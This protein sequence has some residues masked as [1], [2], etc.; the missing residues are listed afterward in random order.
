MNIEVKR[1]MEKE[2]V[3]FLRAMGVENGQSLLDFGCG[4]GHYTIPAS[5]AVGKNGRIYALDKD[6]D[7]LRKLRE[8]ARRYNISNIEL[9]N[10]KS[11][12]PI[13]DKNIDVVL[14]YD[15]I[16]YEEKKGRK[17]IYLE[18]HRVLKKQGLF[19]VYPK[20]H[21]DDYPRNRLSIMGLN[22]IIKEI[23]ESGFVL[24]YRLLK[25]LLH[26][27]YLNEGYVL[28]FRKY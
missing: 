25:K 10:E 13:E 14:C 16:H 4:V 26:D 24:E 28:N 9:I 18:A 5:I 12:I 15:I 22:D 27:E 7:V 11:R 20:H 1:W 3:I 2:G 21:R 6:I 8:T 23:E 17:A 19:S